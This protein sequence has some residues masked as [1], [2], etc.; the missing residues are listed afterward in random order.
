MSHQS[1]LIATDIEAYLAEHER[2]DLLRFLTCGS[3]D[4]GNAI[5]REDAP[6]YEMCGDRVGPAVDRAVTACRDIAGD[7]FGDEGGIRVACGPVIEP[8]EDVGQR[9]GQGGAVV[10]HDR[11]V[12]P[13]FA[14]DRV[15]GQSAV[16]GHSG[17]AARSWSRVRFEQWHRRSGFRNRVETGARLLAPCGA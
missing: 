3:V 9:V 11:P 10:Q 2:K 14:L 13:V 1:E 12:G 16:R 4:D 6:C 17:I 15:G 5:T 7:P 8:F